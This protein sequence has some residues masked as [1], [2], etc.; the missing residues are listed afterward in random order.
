M[1][2]H[3]KVDIKGFHPLIGFKNFFVKI[4]FSECAQI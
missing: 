3:R 1:S 4:D 2:P